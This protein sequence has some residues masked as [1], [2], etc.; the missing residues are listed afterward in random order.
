MSRCSRLAWIP[1]L[2][3]GL[4]I[5]VSLRAIIRD[6]VP[7]GIL[8]SV[9]V[10]IAGLLAARFMQRAVLRPPSVDRGMAHMLV[11]A[12]SRGARSL[13]RFTPRAPDNTRQRASYLGPVVMLA[14]LVLPFGAGVWPSGLIGGGLHLRTLAGGP[15]S[16]MFGTQALAAGLLALGYWVADG[17]EVGRV[18]MLLAG[19]NGTGAGTLEGTVRAEPGAEHEA[20]L[21]RSSTVSSLSPTNSESPDF[22][23]S[24]DEGG[25][26]TLVVES[27]SGPVQINVHK[28]DWASDDWTVTRKSQRTQI[29]AGAHVVMA[30]GYS[31]D[32]GVTQRVVLFATVRDAPVQVLR[33]ALRRRTLDTA[34]TLAAAVSIGILAMLVRVT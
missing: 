22:H 17:A 25:V 15:L 4:S 24:Y 5:A 19:H 26:D 27:R 9:A 20:L 8:A 32:A 12:F 34:V 10:G 11:R 14:W 2:G 18:R 21:H 31:D 16:L 1:W 3:A 29:R 23:A 30:G 6:P 7:Q 33:R 13:P 28:L